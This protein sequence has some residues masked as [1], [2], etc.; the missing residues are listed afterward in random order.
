MDESERHVAELLARWQDATVA[1]DLAERLATDA[2]DALTRFE[3]STE[4]ARLVSV[5]A[6]RVADA[7]ERAAEKARLAADEV[8]KLAS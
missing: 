4:A 3:A 5:L 8:S 2:A 1:A 6:R 7:A